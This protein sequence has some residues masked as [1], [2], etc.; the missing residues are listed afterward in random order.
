MEIFKPGL[1][2]IGVSGQVTVTLTGNLASWG[3]QVWK[4]A[5][6]TASVLLDYLACLVALRS[7]SQVLYGEAF[8]Q[9]LGIGYLGREE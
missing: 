8:G 1:V 4:L 7:L 3:T 6:G 2:Y 5:K 9:A